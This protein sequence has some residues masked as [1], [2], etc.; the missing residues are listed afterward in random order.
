MA[1]A[2]NSR[3]SIA[4]KSSTVPTAAK[5]TT[6]GH[7]TSPET[8]PVADV[9][10]QSRKRPAP[11]DEV[12]EHISKKVKVRSH[13]KEEVRVSLKAPE[14]VGGM[15][16]AVGMGDAGQ[17]GL[18]PDTEERKR[19][20]PVP[21][22]PKNIV[23]VAAGGL[24]SICLDD[25]GRVH[26]WGCNDEG[27][28]GRPTNDEEDNFD[29]GPVEGL[30]GR[31][32]AVTAGDCHC[33]ALTEEGVVWGWG[34]FRDNSGTLGFLRKGEIQPTPVRLPVPPVTQLASGNN[35]L[36]L[37]THDGRVFTAGC[38]ESGQLGRL[39]E[40]FAGRDGVRH[41]NGFDSLLLPAPM[42][43]KPSTKAFDAVWAG[44][45]NT[46]ARCKATGAVYACGLNNYHQMGL[47]STDAV[48]QPKA[49]AS[50]KESA[51]VEVAAGQHHGLVRTSSGTVLAMG[52][53][54][55]GRLGLGGS[56]DAETPQLI[57]G[58]EGAT[59]LS[60][61]GS[62]SVVVCD[63]GSVLGFGM[64]TS[65]QLS[66][67]DDEDVLTP[68]PFGGNALGGRRAVGAGVGGQHSL[69]LVVPEEQ[70]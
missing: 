48:Y 22:L 59:A 64:G 66:Q 47:P 54:E 9:T 6:N 8:S 36:A 13:T 43:V 38:G 28:L 42:R 46:F 17:L 62:V 33:L 41:G 40:R 11:E 34:M 56:S 20:A 57:G 12:P 16:L 21:N 25:Q 63:D 61:E 51:V 24:H 37:L 52:R 26:S 30:E 67:K 27:A 5:V 23:Q 32:V 39:A 4:V 69:V 35:H 2:T 50:L 7:K 19:V 3:K 18:G 31:V 14:V 10:K 60:A 1:R 70:K 53:H 29:A 55:Y 44:G 58:V 68:T 49:V 45:E 65:Q 15:V